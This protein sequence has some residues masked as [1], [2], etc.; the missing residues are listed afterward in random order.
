[1]DC[2]LNNREFKIKTVFDSITTI[3][4][5]FYLFEIGGCK[6]NIDT[7]K[8]KLCDAQEKVDQFSL[9]MGNSTNII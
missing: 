5:H 1:M 7:T 9:V 3:Y 8:A 2:Y 4:V 6:N